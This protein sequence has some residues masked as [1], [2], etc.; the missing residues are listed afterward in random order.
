[1]PKK[2]QQQTVPVSETPSGVPW[3]ESNFL[4][5]G[6]IGIV[7]IV[8][9]ATMHN[10]C[11]L[12]WF[13]WAFFIYTVWN[14][15]RAISRLRWLWCLIGIV[16]VSAALLGLRAAICPKSVPAIPVPKTQSIPSDGGS[17]PLGTVTVQGNCNV[18]SVGDGNNI[19]A[20]CSKSSKQQ[21]GK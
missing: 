18:G 12:L 11:W 8:V 14:G 21:K 17:P 1:M 2:P 19:S 7:L 20:D 10:L 13:A 15:T 5:G 4:W 9:A 3:Y 6:G 16:L